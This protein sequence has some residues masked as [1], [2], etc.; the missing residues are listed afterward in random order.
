VSDVKTIELDELV[1]RL[2][3]ER[4]P[5]LLEAL[6]ARYFESG[7]L[8]GAQPFPH[9]DVAARARAL[10]PALDAPIVVYCASATCANSHRA[11]AELAALGYRDVSVFAGGKQAWVDAGLALVV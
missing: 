11:A 8:P 5:V 10:L 1:R 3:G 9:H 7:H 4:A 2:G 6:P